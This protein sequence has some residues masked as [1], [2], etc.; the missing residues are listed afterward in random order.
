M[1]IPY[2]EVIGDPIAH[3]KSPLIHNFWLEKL[4]I[5]AEYRRV[6]VRSEELVDYIGSRS[7]DPDWRGC[8][9]TVPHKEAVIP[10]LDRLDPLASEVGAVNTIVRNDGLLVGFN[11]DVAGVREP[12]TRLERRAKPDNYVATLIEVIGAGGAARAVGAAFKG[13]EITFYNRTREKAAALANEFSGGAEYGFAAEL[14]DLPK[15]PFVY[16]PG[17]PD[18][19]PNRGEHQRY[20]YVIVNA[21]TLGMAGQPE[22]PINLDFY[23]DDTIVFD[24]VYAPPETGLL[25]AA[26]AR[27]MRT[28]DGLEMLVGQAASAFELFFGQ[29]APREYDAE[30]RS[31]LTA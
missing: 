11:T 29:P 25:K 6:H 16:D 8:N 21:S 23:P 5:E 24:M 20:N 31:L 3:S 12:F 27:N 13:G 19:K 1:S 26:R 14:D 28:I 10:I 7:A 17:F 2:A 9:V 30:L 18:V 4:G 22:V 15:Q